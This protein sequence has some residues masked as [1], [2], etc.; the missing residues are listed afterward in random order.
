MK[1]P[2]VVLV[3][4][5][6]LIAAGPLI[7][8]LGPNEASGVGTGEKVL[9][10]CIIMAMTILRAIRELLDRADISESIV[11][12]TMAGE[13]PQFG[14]GSGENLHGSHVKICCVAKISRSRCAVNRRL[15]V[16]IKALFFPLLR[17]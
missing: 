17:L 13:Q 3:S 15:D 10:S 1:P 5:A 11:P 9:V 4:S 16:E 2:I 14:N 7:G 8:P 6:S 12:L